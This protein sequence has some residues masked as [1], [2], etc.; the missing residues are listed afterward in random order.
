MQLLLLLP[1][2]LLQVLLPYKEQCEQ[3][4]HERAALERQ[5]VAWRS[6]RLWPRRTSQVEALLAVKCKLRMGCAD[7][8]LQRRR[9]DSRRSEK[10]LLAQQ[11]QLEKRVDELKSR[12]EDFTGRAA[13]PAG[14]NSRRGLRI[15]SPSRRAAAAAASTGSPAG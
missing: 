8:E 6:R 9:E 1:L 11:H 12:M 2:L 10:A 15:G 4:K 7:M 14:S 13:A 3:L 5:R